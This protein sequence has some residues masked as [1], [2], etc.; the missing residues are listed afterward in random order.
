M[1]NNENNNMEIKNKYLK[2]KEILNKYNQEHLLFK[3]DKLNIEKQKELL[4]QILN[5][6]FEKMLMLYKKTQA[7]NI[8]IQDKIESISYFEKEKLSNFEKEKYFKIGAEVF[9]QNKFAVI[10]LAGGQGTR[11]GHPGPKGTYVLDV[12]PSKS[13]FAILCE[14]LQ[15][16]NKKYN[17]EI[18]WY[19]M[20]S[21]ENHLKTIEFFKENNYFNYSE[22]KIKFFVQGQIPMLDING[23]ILLTKEG[24]IKQAADGH[25][26][27]FSA[28]VKNNIIKDMKKNNIEWIFTGP[29]DNPLINMTD[30]IFIGIAELEKV[31]V[32]GKSLVKISAQEKV[33]VFCQKNNKPCVIEYTEIA[34]ELAN[35]K[36]KN[37]K[38]LYAESH[39]NCNLF[40][41]KGL[42]KIGTSELPFHIAF[43]KADYIDE[44]G[45]LIIGKEPNSYKFETFIFDGFN[46]LD[47]MVILRVKREDEFAPIKGKTGE[48]SVESAIKLYNAYIK[49]QKI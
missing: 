35:Q 9:K 48:D 30:E 1:L 16:T 2:V 24:L 34:E 19:I 45:K 10:T 8:K 13:L 17:C 36:N 31:L 37:G 23:K 21:K 28:L 40:N 20:T 25:G 46:K 27:I 32:A 26:G 7:I 42:E 14:K 15:I 11:L 43:K 41:I 18:C 3:Y 33:G 38:L 6:D 39:I 44:N 29:V 49:K 47:K 5:I 4:E 12:L 22:K